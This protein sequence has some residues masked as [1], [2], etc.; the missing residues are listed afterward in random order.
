MLNS[1]DILMIYFSKKDEKSISLLAECLINMTC[2]SFVMVLF[3]LK[4][5]TAKLEESKSIMAINLQC[6]RVSKNAKWNTQ[7]LNTNISSASNQMFR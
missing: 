6:N 4:Q 7:N 3:L 5:A 2:W 1:T